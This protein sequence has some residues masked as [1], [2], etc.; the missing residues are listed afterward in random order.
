M[1]SSAGK[2]A[3][4]KAAILT[5][6]RVV[7]GNRRERMNDVTTD[8]FRAQMEAVESLRQESSGERHTL[9]DGLQIVISF[10]DGDE[11]HWM[12][13]S[14]LEERGLK[15]LFFVILD[16]LGRDGYLTV[17]QIRSLAGRGHAIGS[18]SRTHRR[19]DRL[20]PEEAAEEC[21]V[22]KR[23]LEEFA[24]GP[25]DWFAFPGGYH[26]AGSVRAALDAGYR[27]VRTMRWGYAPGGMTGLLPALPVTGFHTPARF[28]RIL[29]GRAAVW[30]YHL[31]SLGKK[32]LPEALY[33]GLRDRIGAGGA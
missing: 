17:E 25:V 27:S 20:S 18:H 8:A 16:R 32:I 19:F 11:S 23:E 3:S 6:H 7:P 15:G 12:A 1:T 30:P 29:E 9:A 2:A 31:K 21:I 28:Q 33:S 13:A 24:G 5:Y 4:G 10:D 26:D 22:S 14:I